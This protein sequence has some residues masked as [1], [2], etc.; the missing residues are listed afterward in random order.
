MSTRNF[1]FRNYRVSYGRV[2][3]GGG[4]KATDCLSWNV[5]STYFRPMSV[6]VRTPL[7][8]DSSNGW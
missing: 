5:V 4:E 2:E 7:R 8:R 3:A 1:T 6:L